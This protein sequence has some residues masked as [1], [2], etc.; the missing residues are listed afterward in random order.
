MIDVPVLRIG[1]SESSCSRCH[2]AALPHESHHWTVPGFGP[3]EPGCGVRFERWEFTYG[4]LTGDRQSGEPGGEWAWADEAMLRI[5]SPD[6]VGPDGY[7][8]DWHDARRTTMPFGVKHLVRAMAA[9]R[10]E[11]CRHPY[12]GGGEWSP[13]DEH[14][15][16]P[17]DDESTRNVFDA[18]GEGSTEARWRILT[19]HHLNGVKWDCRWWNLAALCQRCHLTIQRKV[20]MERVYPFEHSEWF[21]PFAAGWYAFAYLGL[22]V[23]RSEAVERMD[24]FLALERMA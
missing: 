21:K 3:T 4:A 20:L 7:P 11:R 17:F 8:P 13:C 1:R 15:E 16:H 18:S 6:D 19:V 9:Y 10:C 14:C 22:D 24:E 5:Y 2:R 23:S 12:V